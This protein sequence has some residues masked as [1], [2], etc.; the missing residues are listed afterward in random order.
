MLYKNHCF[1]ASKQILWS[2]DPCMTSLFSYL[3]LL[4]Q[5]KTLE[6]EK[7]MFVTFCFPLL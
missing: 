1:K 7:N 3:F 6:E 5:R 2:T 4:D